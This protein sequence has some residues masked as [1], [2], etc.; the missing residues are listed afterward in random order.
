MK[1]YQVLNQGFSEKVHTGYGTVACLGTR[2][3]QS[4]GNY[5]W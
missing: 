1:Q 3:V 4:E 2:L 5:E